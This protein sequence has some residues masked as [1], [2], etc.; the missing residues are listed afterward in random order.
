M[1]TC[2]TQLL[3]F[4]GGQL[5]KSNGP[6]QLFKGLEKPGTPWQPGRTDSFWKSSAKEGGSGAKVDAGE[7]DTRPLEGEQFREE[8]TQTR[9]RREGPLDPMTAFRAPA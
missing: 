8:E 1:F 9:V 7:K 3:P 2:P 6:N 5:C 4:F